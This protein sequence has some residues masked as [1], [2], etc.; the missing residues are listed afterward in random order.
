[1]IKR[2][3][4][5]VVFAVVICSS[6]GA[7]SIVIDYIN[8]KQQISMIG[9]D[10]E[11]SQSFLQ[12][13]ANP[14]EVA[15]WLFKDIEFT[16]CRVSYDK[17]QELVEG[18]KNFSFYDD[19]IKSMKMVKIANPNIK[20]YAT[21]KSDYNGYNN[22]N[23]LPDWIC[24]YRPTTYFYVNKYAAF[25][26]DYLALMH[27]NGLTIHYLS[28]AK[29]WSSVVTVNRTIDI[30][31]ALTPMLSQR[32]VP[33]PLFTDP[34]S[35]SVDQGVS[36]VNEVNSKR[37]AYL[38]HAFS[39]HD[40]NNS[41]SKY[42]NFVTACEN[43][44]KPAWNDETSVGSGGRTIGVEPFVKVLIDNYAAKTDMYR[45]GIAGEI[46]FEN[47]SRGVSAET[48]SIYFT[49]GQKAKRL[50][51]YYVSKVFS[52]H[53]NNHFYVPTTI[54]SMP[55]LKTMSFVDDNEIALCVINPTETEYLSANIR[56][57]N[58][59]VN[60]LVTQHLFDSL[61]IIQGDKKQINASS[62]GEFF[63]N[64]KPNSLNFFRFP[65]KAEANI[66][67]LTLS[68]QELVFNPQSQNA[69]EKKYQTLYF[70][71]KNASSDIRVELVNRVGNSFALKSPSTYS[72]ANILWFIPIEIE[73]DR[74]YNGAFSADLRVSTSEKSITIP[75]SAEV[76]ESEV[77]SLPF[78]E[79]FTNLSVKTT[80]ITNS[81]INSFSDYKG[82]EIHNGYS[83]AADRINVSASEVDPGFFLTPEIDFDGP[84]ELKFNARMLANDQG[85]TAAD[86]IANNIPRNIFAIIGSDTIYDHKKNGATLYQNYNE[87]VS[88]FAFD[89]IERIKILPKVSNQ[90]AWATITDG[91]SFGAK[92]TG[93][94]VQPTSLPTVNVGFGKSIFLGEVA[95]GT[96]K[97][98]T[99]PLKGWN[100]SSNLL[101]SQ[102]ANS[103]L[104]ITTTQFVP[105]SGR[106]DSE[107]NVAIDATFLSTD[108]HIAK[109]TLRSDNNQLKER[110]IWLSFDVVQPTGVD[111]IQSNFK[112]FTAGNKLVFRSDKQSNIKVYSISGIL[113]AESQFT[114]YAEFNLNSGIYIVKIGKEIRK[115]II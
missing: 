34:G 108:T 69:T 10:M 102:S 8:K 81:D 27:T 16:T 46:L 59:V 107:V 47:F 51:S 18:V 36:F 76:L 25:L 87:W 100:L 84:F 80:P 77:V 113:M 95:R 55:N 74:T 65:L 88:T 86:K 60:G 105:V 29:E 111:E 14:Q 17:K 48:R 32:N 41:A 26:A 24:N 13:A 75:L 62:N 20:F 73:L 7:Q 103:E 9:A 89:G 49:A 101:L 104:N 64:I 11:R 4:V 28:V 82:W 63:V 92:A 93:V 79:M 23:N 39:T 112:L 78:I 43:A 68:E 83:S 45:D 85:A 21:M 90:G 6:I 66:E 72:K 109:I 53:I 70:S 94:R 91:L 71:S 52:N 97:Q 58:A 50:R 38:F 96:T 54:N 12:R 1:M 5:F 31:N 35:W 44:G 106:V 67:T 30:I 98:F 19:A 15:D 40:Y 37:A 114:N 22:E 3:I 42:P 56:I 33:I 57:A 115:I 110:T 2:N 61:T 99:F